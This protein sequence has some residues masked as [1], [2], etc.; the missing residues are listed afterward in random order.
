MT[1]YLPRVD[2]GDGFGP[3][4]ALREYLGFLPNLFPAQSLLPRAIEA[5]ARIAGTVLIKTVGLTR[6]QKES[7]LLALSARSQNVYCTTAHHH[8]LR[9]IGLD[10]ERADWLTRD[11]RKAGFS[12]AEAALLDFGLK[13][14]RRPTSIGAGDIEVLRAQKWTDLQI[15]E[16]ILVTAL[17]RFLC[18]LSVGLGVPPD[19]EP[20]IPPPN[21]NGSGAAAR[22]ASGARTAVGGPYLARPDVVEKTFPPFVFFK[23]SFGFV[24]NIF[25]AQTLRPDVL[26]AEAQAV[27]DILLTS[28][29]L[30]RAQKEYILLVISA[31]NQNTYC[32]AVHCEMLR[33]LGVDTEISDQIAIDHRDSDLSDP[34]KALLDA[35]LKMATRPKDYAEADVVGL[36]EHGFTERQILEAIVMAS[37]TNMLNTLQMGLGAVPDFPPRRS[38]SPE[39]DEGVNPSAGSDRLTGRDGKSLPAPEDPDSPLVVRARSGD[40]TAFEELVRSHQARVYRTLVGIVGNAE[41]AEDGTQSVFVKVFRKLGDFAGAS[42]FS[43]WLTRIAV[44][45]GLERVRSRRDVESLEERDEDEFRPSRV[46]AWEEDPESV[47]ARGEMRRIVQDALRALPVLYRTAVMLRDIEQLSTAEAA[48][49][50]DLP[51]ATLKTRL[52][53][54]RLMLREA[55]AAHFIPARRP[56]PV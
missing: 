49:A 31:A 54:G 35:T 20:R 25:R 48:A 38:F 56:S 55:L 26:E 46:G 19:F 45:E 21:P 28:D 11:H 17:T 24:P 14:G 40:M 7:I 27:R 50:L 30:P 4:L 23:K 47:V 22:R 12:E 42:R 37:L 34:D 44:N 8:V 6:P 33:A 3:F 2:L 15:L 9:S 29:V 41:D 18:T 1:P 5:E 32:V 16:A 10:E 52:L 36:L 51:V 43:T 13:L 53:R 39:S